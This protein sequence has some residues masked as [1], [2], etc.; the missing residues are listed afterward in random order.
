MKR[1]LTLLLIA[2]LLKG[3]GA[4]AQK[5]NKQLKTIPSDGDAQLQVKM[6]TDHSS[7]KAG[8][9]FKLGFYF[10]LTMRWH[11]YPPASEG[12]M[13]TVIKLNLPK[14]FKVIK[15]DWPKPNLVSGKMA[16]IMEEAYDEDFF[17]VY[18]IQSPTD[19]I[20]KQ[21]ISA[22]LEWQCCDPSICILGGAK[23]E[24]SF[25]MGKQKKKNKLY[26]YVN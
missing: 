26:K 16:G 8:E 11:T 13:P 3:F 12:S 25:I 9:T 5:P 20:G 24:T 14:G 4:F 17:V 15:E 2:I 10:D 19:D 6:F 23:L 7:V 21:K 22:S 1:Y 18:T